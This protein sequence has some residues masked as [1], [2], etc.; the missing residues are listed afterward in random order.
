M[1]TASITG[2]SIPPFEP[3]VLDGRLYGRGA[4]DTKA[5]LAAMMHA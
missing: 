1:D 5:G 2:M 4:C 3:N